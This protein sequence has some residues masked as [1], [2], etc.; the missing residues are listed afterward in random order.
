MWGGVPSDNP[1][2]QRSL[3]LQVTEK[4]QGGSIQRKLTST[5][6][7]QPLDPYA[8]GREDQKGLLYVLALW[9]DPES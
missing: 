5:E 6:N 4:P 8:E 1:T 7:G 2:P 9:Q 3:T